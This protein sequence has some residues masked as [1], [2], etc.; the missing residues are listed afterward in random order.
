MTYLRF[1]LGIKLIEMA[2]WLM[3]EVV[4]GG[5]DVYGRVVRAMRAPYKLDEWREKKRT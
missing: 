4:E 3:P 1:W 5:E 2:L